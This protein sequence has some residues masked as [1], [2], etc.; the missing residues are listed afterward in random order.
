MLARSPEPRVASS[1]DAMRAGDGG[2][3]ATTNLGVSQVLVPLALLLL[4]AAGY[5]LIYTRQDALPVGIGSNLFPSERMLKG[6]VVYRDFYMIQT[7]GILFYNLWL[8]KLFGVSLLTSLRGVLVFKVLTVLM[9]FVVARRVVG[10]RLALVPALL[11]FVW[12]APGGPFR[13]APIQHEMLFALLAVFFTLRWI[14]RRTFVDPL[15]AGLAV[16]LLAMFKQNT[17]VYCAAALALS[18]LVDSEALPDKLRNAP[19]FLASCARRNRKAVLAALLGIA[20][21]AAALVVYLLQHDALGPMISTFV[22]SPA[23]HIRLKL[24][25]YPLPKHVLIVAVG[26]VGAL[27]AAAYLDSRFTRLKPEISTGVILGAVVCATLL[28]GAAVDNLLFWFQPPLFAWAG[29]A[30][31]RRRGYEAASRDRAAL[32]VLSLFSIAMFL[33]SFPRSV[34][35]LIIGSLPIA[36]VLAVF[37]FDRL[38]LAPDATVVPGWKPLIRRQGRLAFVVVMIVM[39]VL[40]LKLVVPRYLSRGGGFSLIAKA[41]IEPAFDRARGVYFPQKQASEMDSIVALIRERVPEDGFFFAHAL[42]ATNY[43][44]LAARNSP[45]RAMLW[46]GAGTNDPER[47][48]TLESIRQNNV[49]LVV[50]SDRAL[51]AE[52]YQPLLDYLKSDFRQTEVIGRMVILEKEH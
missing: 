34:R 13:P 35:G 19:G 9:V 11:S 49:R 2:L 31:F 26:I 16:G 30:Y 46:N 7:P 33:E 1:G 40:A 10:W 32:L 38:R 43:Y 23:S 36:F 50:T 17:G 21:P 8:F 44:F 25:G 27:A 39:F 41:I 52:R 47:V 12:L 29:W 3:S 5:C 42:E 18:L 48:R 20:M 24:T 15:L 45:T 28:P 51:A 4:V 6:E 22:T 37:L 14:E